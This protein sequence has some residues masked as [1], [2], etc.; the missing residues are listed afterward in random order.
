M[1]KTLE[2]N[3]QRTSSVQAQSTPFV[4]FYQAYPDSLP[5]M[6]A[7]RSALGTL[8][9]QATQY[10]EAVTTASAFGWYVF[11]ASS[12]SLHFDGVDVY[13]ID[14]NT[15][16]KFSVLQ[17]PDIEQWWNKHCP[18]DLMDM[19]PPFL[20]YL[21][22]PGY[23]QIWSGLLV[24]TRKDWSVLV[25]PIA[26]VPRS[27]Q[28]F[29]FEGIVETDEYSP[30]PLFINL[31]LQ[32]TNTPIEFSS[33]EPLFQVQPIKRECYSKHTLNQPS[34]KEVAGHEGLSDL[35]WQSYSRTVRHIDPRVDDHK[36]GR[37]A[38]ESRRRSKRAPA[39]K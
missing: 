6:R 28:Y 33:T 16:E 35:Q 4:T 36:A 20:T 17:L 22:I 21:G 25:R 15:R 30:A 23:I 27:N 5:P 37:Y 7:D 24:E 10:C 9:A 32:V 11:P 2:S 13:L 14:G 12:F 8:P 29:C 3:A 34:I 18:R 39:S 38:T 26:N 31:K 19:A 1:P